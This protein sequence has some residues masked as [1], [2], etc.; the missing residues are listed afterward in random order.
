MNILYIIGNG[1]DIAHK[2]ETS[3][4][5]FFN[6]Y[7]TLLSDDEDVKAMKKDIDSKRYKTWADLEIGLGLYSYN[8]ADKEVFLKCLMDVKARLKEY[9]K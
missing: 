7:L 5:D 1:L 4:Q 9:L 2:M 3:Y 6:H 8:C